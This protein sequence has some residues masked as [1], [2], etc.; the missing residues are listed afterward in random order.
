MSLDHLKQT[1]VPLKVEGSAGC[2]HLPGWHFYFRMHRNP[3][4]LRLH[5]APDLRGPFGGAIGQ[6]LPNRWV[7]WCLATPGPVCQGSA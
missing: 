2:L 5:G 3:L 1:H 6:V 7:L 4:F